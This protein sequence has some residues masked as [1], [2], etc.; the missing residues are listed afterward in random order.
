MPLP[1]TRF[2]LFFKLL[3]VIYYGD[4]ESLCDSILRRN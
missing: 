3:V 1:G 4:F 2:S